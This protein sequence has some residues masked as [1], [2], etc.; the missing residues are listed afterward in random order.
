MNRY[1]RMPHRVRERVVVVDRSYQSRCPR[2]YAVKHGP[3]L[4]RRLEGAVDDRGLRSRK[5]SSSTLSE[6]SRRRSAVERRRG[7]VSTVGRHAELAADGRRAL[8]D[9]FLDLD[10]GLL[11][12]GLLVES[13]GAVDD[14]LVLLPA[15]FVP[16]M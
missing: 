16:R 1:L 2:A 12:R 3:A 14:L 6:A 8:P 4:S 15:T 13:P 10:L 5:W 11:N 9:E 7:A